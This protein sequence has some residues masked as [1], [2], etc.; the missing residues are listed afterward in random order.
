[1]LAVVLTLLIG[2]LCGVDLYL[3]SYIET[4]F[5]EGEEKKIVDGTIAIRKVHNHGFAL[6]KGESHP[7]KVRMASA[8]V[9][10]VLTVYYIFLFR[11]KG[12]WMRKTG[13]AFA[14][15][16]G[17]SNTYDRMVRK[18]VVDYFGFRTKWKRLEKITF[19]LGDM[20]IFLGSVLVMIS[21]LFRQKR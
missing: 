5:K 11:K 7:R 21:D 1:M 15:S 9:C 2:V 16:G 13:V 6:N 19:N 14:L 10:M 17:V 4:H 8:I 3:K 20:F 18:Y 12:D